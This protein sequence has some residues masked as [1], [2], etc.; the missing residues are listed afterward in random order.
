MPHL[1]SP[2]AR[3][4]RLLAAFEPM[5]EQVLDRL[6]AVEH[7]PLRPLLTLT[8]RAADVLAPWIALSV[9]WLLGGTPHARTAVIRGWTATVIAVVIENAILK[10]LVQRDRPDADRMP[11]PQRRNV[12][13]SSSAFPSG[14]VG[15]GTAFAVAA[16]PHLPQRR[17][18]LYVMA[19]VVAYSRVYT[20]RH[21][22]SD[23]LIGS[24]VGAAAGVF[25]RRLF[26]MH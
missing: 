9:R 2:S 20:G 19:G 22:L 5:D 25:T 23:V 24:L 10:P 11:A 18:T 8:A 6:A 15:A 7:G 26:A 3:A 16:S 17:V 21:Y 4:G 13:P 14:H 1:T 12:G